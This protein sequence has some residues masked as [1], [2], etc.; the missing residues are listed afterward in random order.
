MAKASKPRAARK[1]AAKKG[2]GKTMGA[3]DKM[4]EQLNREEL[5]RLQG[6]GAPPPPPPAPGGAGQGG[7]RASGGGGAPPPP[8][9]R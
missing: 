7:P 1:M 6:A 2:K 3:G 9:A 4:T 5:A 8:P